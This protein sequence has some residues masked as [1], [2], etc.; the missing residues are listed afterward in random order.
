MQSFVSASLVLSTKSSWGS[1]RYGPWQP[2]VLIR[3]LCATVLQR[4]ADILLDT[5]S[6]PDTNNAYPQMLCHIWNLATLDVKEDDLDSQPPAIST[7][8]EGTY[9]L[10]VGEYHPGASLSSHS[11]RNEPNSGGIEGLV[12][13]NGSGETEWGGGWG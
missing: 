10:M 2:S 12:R 6:I 13:V 8:L 5:Y 4:R 1:R 11:E 7:I 3:R 9:E